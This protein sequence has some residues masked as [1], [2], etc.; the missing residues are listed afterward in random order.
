MIIL[1]VIFWFSLFL[2][3]H[4]YILFP[5]IL[6]VLTTGKKSGTRSTTGE[7]DEQIPPE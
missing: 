2:I 3:F 7:P 4:T 6:Q 1:Q 5:A